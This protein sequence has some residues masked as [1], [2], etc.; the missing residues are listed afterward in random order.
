MTRERFQGTDTF[1]A[2]EDLRIA[3]AMKVS[4]P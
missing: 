3:V 4:V 1:I 2:T